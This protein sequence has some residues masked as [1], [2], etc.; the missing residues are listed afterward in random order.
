[1]ANG[2]LS[3]VVVV[4][5]AEKPLSGFAHVGILGIH[6]PS[7][8][9]KGWLAILCST[10]AK[11]GKQLLLGTRSG[12]SPLG[13]LT[14]RARKSAEDHKSIRRM[15]VARAKS[16]VPKSATKVWSHEQRNQ[17]FV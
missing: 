3:F 2:V 1:M 15:I 13:Y 6:V 8:E 17:V 16:P 12:K 10:D 9:L 5:L 14:S 7:T 4:G 11:P